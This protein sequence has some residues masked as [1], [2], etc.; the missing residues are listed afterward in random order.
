MA[1]LHKKVTHHHN[2]CHLPFIRRLH[3]PPATLSLIHP[4]LT[5]CILLLSL[6][7]FTALRTRQGLRQSR[8]YWNS[9][10]KEK[11]QQADDQA[12][13]QQLGRGPYREVVP[14]DADLQGRH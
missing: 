12:F 14:T 4:Q 9:L 11:E 3:A 13:A 6:L 10:P 5:T 2:A 1:G 7:D 8:S